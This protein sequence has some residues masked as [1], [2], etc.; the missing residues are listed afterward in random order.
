MQRRDFIRTATVAGAG[1]FAGTA[2]AGEGLNNQ[3]EKQPK[4]KLQY[5]ELGKT[6]A[7][8]SIVGF[9]GIVVS[10]VPQEEANDRVKRAVERGINYFDVAPTYGNA[11]EILGPALEPF[12]DQVF[13]SCKTRE[14]D[15]EGAQKE[16]DRSL[17]RMRTDHFDL[18]LLHAIVNPQVDVERA[19]E[20]D[21]AMKTL[22]K[23]RDEGKVRSLGFSAHSVEAAL[24]AL[25]KFEFDVVM[26]PINWVCDFQEQFS[27]PVR[28]KGGEMGCGFVALK[29]FVEGHY[30]KGDPRE[31]AKCWYKPIDKDALARMS[32][33]YTLSHEGVATALPPGQPELFEMAV[34]IAERHEDLTDE[35]LAQLKEMSGSESP[36]FTT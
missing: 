17:E 9:G 14:R 36:L 28:E 22:L 26:Y 34:D 23:A 2:F 25:E 8:L 20:K 4:S 27:Q 5:R 3:A 11:E 10:G 35:Q 6:G 29:T 19:F 13:L 18:Y 30:Q 1:A 32:L 24:L 16:M 33:A 12:R 31:Y 7:E 21:G 15:A